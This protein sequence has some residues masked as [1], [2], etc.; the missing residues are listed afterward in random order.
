[1]RSKNTIIAL[2]VAILLAI[3]SYVV[4]TFVGLSGERGLGKPSPNGFYLQESATPVMDDLTS[5]YN[6][7]SYIIGGIVAFV[8]GLMAYI[9]IRYR[10]KANPVPS[11]TSH[12]TLIEVIWTIVPVLILIVIAIP[13][14]N[15]LYKQDVIKDTEVTV[16]A[17][18]NTWNWSY[19]YP[20]HENVEEIISNPLDETQSKEAGKPYL[21]ATDGA[22]VVPV[23]TNVKV[24][25]TSINNMHAWTVPSFGIKMDAV[26]GIINETWFRANQTGTFYGQCSEI[27]GI[28]HYYMPI[29]VKVVSKAEYAQWIANDGSFTTSVAQNNSIVGGG[30]TAAQK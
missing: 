3:V 4:L 19:T 2:V 16:K 1:M 21:L 13:S 17:V 9:M 29:E 24:L 20:D 15:L 14:M 22:L 23:D 25:V 12:N 5:V 6:L 18:G 30:Q 11:K 10:E 27:C 7:V 28:K 8:L 26:P